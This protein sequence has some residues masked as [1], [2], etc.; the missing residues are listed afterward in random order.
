[1]YIVQGGISNA[2]KQLISA[3]LNIYELSIIGDQEFKPRTLI[4]LFEC[5]KN[6]TEFYCS[7]ATRSDDVQKFV[8]KF[9]QRFQDEWIINIVDQSYR[10]FEVFASKRGMTSF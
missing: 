2:M 4:Q 9:Q 8:K 7:F 3:N 1:M 6:L 5:C 10:Y